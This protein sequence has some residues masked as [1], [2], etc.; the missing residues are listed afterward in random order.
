M[1][2]SVTMLPS[3]K[4]ITMRIFLDTVSS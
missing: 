2:D 4:V 1:Q 3:D